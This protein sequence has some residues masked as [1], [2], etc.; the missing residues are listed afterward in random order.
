VADDRHPVISEDIEQISQRAS[1]AAERVVDIWRGVGLAVPEQIGHDHG[2][3]SR[4]ASNHFPPSERV[5]KQAVD[6]QNRGPA[7]GDPVNQSVAV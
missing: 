7:A 3:G 6:Q 4:Q 1:M 2:V 5:L